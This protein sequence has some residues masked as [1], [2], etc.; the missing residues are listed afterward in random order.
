MD[1]LL[2]SCL[3]LFLA[4]ALVLCL[5][6]P[7]CGFLTAQGTVLV[8]SCQLL[9]VNLETSG[10]PTI[11]GQHFVVKYRPGDE[12][13]ARMVLQEAE[14]V[15]QPLD[16][17]CGYVPGQAVPILVYPDRDSLNRIFGWGS[18]E[19]AMGVYWAGVIRVLAPRAWMPDVP[20][21]QQQLVFAE[22]GPVAHEYTH[23]LVDYKTRGNYPRWLTEGLAEYAEHEIA[24]GAQ[25]E[26]ERL[27]ITQPLAE[28]DGRFDDPVWQDYSYAV[29]EDLV[30][31]LVLKYGPERIPVLL[32]ALGRGRPLTEAFRQVYGIGLDGFVQS[33]NIEKTLESSNTKAGRGLIERAY[34]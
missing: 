33:Y 11:R 10:W 7:V 21:N 16:N 5:Q 20:A 34:V 25:P 19:S 15:Y 4:L 27:T 23:L 22:Q 26:L 18:N 32:N 28:L 12:A 30:S 31:Y 14:R 1:R 9:L 3:V 2:G 29:A 6:I 17:F 8:R 24:G 13:D